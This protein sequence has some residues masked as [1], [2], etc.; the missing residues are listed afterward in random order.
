MK[1]PLSSRSLLFG[2]GLI[3]AGAAAWFWATA[4][5]QAFSEMAW[6]DRARIGELL[7]TVTGNPETYRPE[8]S[9]A[10]RQVFER[11][12]PPTATQRDGLRAAGRDMARLHRQYWAD[13]REAAA[14]GRPTRSAERRRLEQRLI[15]SG[16]LAPL[17]L[18]ANADLMKRIAA[19]EAI[20]TN[21]GVEMVMDGPTIARVLES[22]DDLE[23]EAV[24]AGLLAD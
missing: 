13:A 24:L 4:R 20:T 21:H 2:A 5:P 1:E 11:Y 16:F 12:A 7:W 6:P 3:V 15:A 19:H 22:Q 18:Q 14:T 9:Q 23:T 17:R 8:M 10:L